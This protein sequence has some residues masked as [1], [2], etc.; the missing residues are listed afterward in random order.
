MDDIVRINWIGSDGDDMIVTFADGH[1]EEITGIDNI[2]NYLKNAAG[3]PAD[4]S[5][6][7]I[8]DA[9]EGKF[10]GE[11]TDEDEIARLRENVTPEVEDE[12]ADINAN[13]HLGKGAVAAGAALGALAGVGGT[14]GVQA[15]QGQF[16]QR[17]M[18]V[19]AMNGTDVDTDA[20]LAATTAADTTA[21]DTTADDT[22]TTNDEETTVTATEDTSEF[23][24]L[25][26]SMSEN[27]LR[28]VASED[29]MNLVET[30]HTQTHKEGNFRLEED[31]ETYLDLSFE[32]ALVLSTYANY[33]EPADIYEIFGEYDITSEEA[34]DLLE[35]ARSKMITYYMNSVEPSGLA[36]IF[37]DEQAR[38]YF[39]QFENDVLRFN[40]EHTTEASD[41]VI[42]DVYY[43]YIL[44]GATN[45][46]TSNKLARLLAFDTVYGGLNLVESA[47]T[48]HTQFLVFH[49][50]G[51]EEETRYLVEN[52]YGLNFDELTEEEKQTYRMNIIESGT[53]LV[54]L[55]ENGQVMNE[56][57]STQEERDAHLS[58]TELVDKMGLCNEV[59][60]EI[61]ELMTGLDNM[62]AV[63]R[64]N[65]SSQITVINMQ[66]LQGLYQS[67]NTDLAN[68]VAANIN[69]SLSED[70]LT[71][72][73]K[74]SSVKA[75]AENYGT[76]V[77]TV[78]QDNRPTM[79]QI[80]EAAHAKLSTLD[81]YAG[82]SRDIATL[83]NNRR[84]V[85]YRLDL[86]F[87][88]DVYPSGDY[89]DEFIIENGD[90]ISE[91]EETVTEEVGEDDLT[92]EEQEE[93][94]EQ[95]AVIEA[96]LALENA[97]GYGQTAAN[98]Y[99]NSNSYS[100]GQ[101]VTDPANNQTYNLDDMTFA[102]GLAYGSAFGGVSVST[103]DGQIQAAADA[104]AE[105]YLNGLSA[106]EQEAIA[107][108]MGTDWAS[109][110]SQLKD[111]FISGY[112]SQMQ[113]EISTAIAVGQEMKQTSDAAIAEMEEL[114]NQEEQTTE[115]QT[116]EEQT[117]EET[118]TEETVE[119]GEVTVEEGQQEETTEEQT[120]EEQTTEEQTTEETVVEGEV[121]VEDEQQEETHEE[122]TEETQTEET[123]VEGEQGQ[124]DETVEE[125]VEQSDV[126]EE[127]TVEGTEEYD[128]QTD[129]SRTE[130]GE[131]VITEGE[132][133]VEDAGTDEVSDEEAAR[134]EREAAEAAARA[135]AAEAAARAEA[136]EAERQAEAQ[137][138]AEEAERQAEAQRQ[139]EAEA[140]AQRQA[141]AEA[142]AQA[143]AEA[144]AAEEAYEEEY[145]S[146]MS[147]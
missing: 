4:A 64:G 46:A 25:M 131:V 108:G 129:T 9:Y 107:R 126:V 119:E 128:E 96:S 105:N 26:S 38:T 63:E 50:M 121:T 24:T 124:G 76:M 89:S 136:E 117:T 113:S 95:Q 70:L 80:I 62:E 2:E 102:N 130:E 87:S 75:Y 36:Q 42:R 27:D 112:M 67:G 34:M 18:D 147:K 37:H 135:E 10:A 39:E 72:I 29:A 30:F 81:H 53:E 44:D 90:V 21:A 92:P 73:A 115:E 3:L 82:D 65:A 97:A 134:V 77:S 35:S 94:E 31:G 66:I 120:T 100:F 85:D 127:G 109:A 91:T 40:A 52:I 15:L 16:A 60:R 51:A 106:D 101:S 142:A 79:G 58:L 33:S 13:H 104:A 71:R 139:A 110:R 19:D 48:E 54:D 41:Q 45:D 145:G 23:A 57:N 47:S 14:L 61:K 99:A 116:T 8:A 123:V 78:N 5:T 98:S 138:Q 59:E 28:R 12:E 20:D 32:E 137:R 6:D 49:G 144:A 69:T 17:Q 74:V 83:V 122:T 68:E 93:V 141:E 11:V 132:V 43:N 103:D 86:D 84:H 7:D 56:E 118:Q 88:G 143:Q 55:L 111:K 1:A 114:N 146:S 133:P 125:T 22:T 140:E